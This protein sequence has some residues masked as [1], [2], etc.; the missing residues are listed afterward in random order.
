LLAHGSTAK[1]VLAVAEAMTAA[2]TA[3]AVVLADD[4]G[5]DLDAA[6]A[7]FLAASLRRASGQAWLSTRRPEVVRAFDPTEVLR[8]TRSHGER[9]HH[10]LAA[11]TDKKAR[12]ARRQLHLLL[13]PAMTTRSVALLEGPHD[14]E[15][16]GAVAERRLMDCGT[17]PPAAYGVRMIAAGT[18]ETGGKDELPKLAGLA[19]ELGFHVRVLIDSDKPGS[20]T[21]LLAKLDGLAEQVIRLPERT[22]VERALV[23]GLP[24]DAQRIALCAVNDLYGL[25]LNVD[26]I[27]DGALEGVIVKQLKQK[28]G[29]HQPFVAALPDGVVPLLAAEVLDTL[30]RPPGQPALMELQGL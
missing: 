23:R 27:A 10:Q 28:S 8:L 4:F 18:G 2:D 13:L 21:V 15:G 12:L 5:D 22:A 16:Y 26:D 7:E 19:Q 3:G 9:R 20:D 30:T 11:T 6:S 29:L 14:L 25:G 24:A 1:G 17:P